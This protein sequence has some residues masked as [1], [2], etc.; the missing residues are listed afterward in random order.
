MHIFSPMMTLRRKSFRCTLL[1]LPLL[2]ISKQPAGCWTWRRARGCFSRRTTGSVY[3]RRKRTFG[4]CT[5]GSGLFQTSRRRPRH[6]CREIGENFQLRRECHH[7]ARVWDARGDIAPISHSTRGAFEVF[8]ADAFVCHDLDDPRPA[9][10]RVAE[11]AADL[12]ARA[13]DDNAFGDDDM[14]ARPVLAEGERSLEERCWQPD[15]AGTSGGLRRK[16]REM[17]PG[18]GQR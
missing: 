16:I 10:E 11:L 4:L 18:P 7:L 1:G 3:L 5:D 2:L 15:D 8:N 6:I 9:L 14:Q 13:D 17:V 12:T